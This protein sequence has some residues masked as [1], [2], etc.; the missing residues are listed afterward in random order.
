MQSGLCRQCSKTLQ[1]V[2]PKVNHT[3]W[4]DTRCRRSC[5]IKIPAREY[6]SS[7][8]NVIC[9]ETGR[10]ILIFLWHVVLC[11]YIHQ[12]FSFKLELA[13]YGFWIVSGYLLVSSLRG[14]KLLL[15]KL[16]IESPSFLYRLL[17]THGIVISNSEF[18]LWMFISALIRHTFFP[19]VISDI[20]GSNVEQD[21]PTN[22]R[23]P[24]L[25]QA[26]Q[27]YLST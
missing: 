13:T 1:E 24:C 8:Y 18:P 25:F 11:I 22:E 7:I 10:H 15:S 12:I 23:S 4:S 3:V 17:S 6:Q 21:K 20:D 27:H 9:T 26:L 16:F 14:R 19:P 5:L 2:L